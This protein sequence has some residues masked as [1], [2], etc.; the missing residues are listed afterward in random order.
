M[1]KSLVRGGCRPLLST[2]RKI[3]TGTGS[4]KVYQLSPKIPIGLWSNT[5]SP[6]FCWFEH[7]IDLV[8][9]CLGIGSSL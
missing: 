3:N 6:D 2:G 9:R 5:H 7:F 1:F 4:C 8:S